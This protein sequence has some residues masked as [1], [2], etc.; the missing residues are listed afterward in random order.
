[1][2][3]GANQK[4]NS[5]LVIQE[6]KQA[7]DGQAEGGA[8]AGAAPGEDNNVLVVAAVGNDGC[9]CLQVRAAVPSVL[10]A[11]ALSADGEPLE[12]SNWGRPTS[13]A[14]GFARLARISKARRPGGGTVSLTGS[15]FA[16]PIVSGVAAL[17]LSAQVQQ[18]RSPDPLAVREA[19]LHTGR[20]LPAE[21]QPGVPPVSLSAL[22]IF[23]G[24]TPP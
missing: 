4:Q 19:L 23:L 12:S 11:G 1:M 6:T 14:T 2:A 9:S 8:R 15:S 22:K 10:G 21:G 17:L 7:S 18:G 20:S 16:T 5:R 3:K 24:H 13:C